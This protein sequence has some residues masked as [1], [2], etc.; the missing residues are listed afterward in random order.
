MKAVAPAPGAMW[1]EVM[2]AELWLSL[3]DADL[4]HFNAMS[5]DAEQLFCCL[6]PRIGR[7]TFSK[8]VQSTLLLS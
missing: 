7:R 5:E 8:N 3:Q 4:A 1:A 2:G 6:D